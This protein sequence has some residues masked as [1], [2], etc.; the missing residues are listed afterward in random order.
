MGVVLSM[1]ALL[2]AMPADAREL[3]SVLRPEDR[4][5]VLALLGPVDPVEGPADGLL[6]GLASAREAWTARDDAGRIICM[7]GVSP[8]SLIGSTGV[9][10]LLGSDLV[11]VHRRAFMVESRR[12]VAHWLT[13]YDELR[14]VVDA[15]YV[16]AIRWLRWLGFEIGPPFAQAH[17]LF[18]RVSKEVT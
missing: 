17:G 1:T 18:R 16:V 14:N 2:P 5:E 7:A 11:T 12:L 15:R 9:P 8:L 13:L 3:A 4:A 6:Q 10:W